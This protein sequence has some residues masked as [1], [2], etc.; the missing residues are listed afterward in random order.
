MELTGQANG[1]QVG[2]GCGKQME[3]EFDK[4]P[5]QTLNKIAQSSNPRCFK[6]FAQRWVL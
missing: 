3:L 6:R 4:A 1:G 5:E 2:G